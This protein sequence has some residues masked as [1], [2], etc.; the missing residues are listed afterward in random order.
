MTPPPYH[1]IL[2]IL[3]KL[4][5][6]Q[7]SPGMAIWKIFNRAGDSSDSAFEYVKARADIHMRHR[8]GSTRTASVAVPGRDRL[9]A[10]SGPE[11]RALQA[12]LC[13]SPGEPALQPG[14]EAETPVERPPAGPPPSDPPPQ[15][16]TGFPLRRRRGSALCP[17][18]FCPPSCCLGD[19]ILLAVA[20]ASV[21]LATSSPFSLHP[22]AC[23][24]PGPF[25]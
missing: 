14:A 3:I 4:P 7:N 19:V 18:A 1:V 13:G 10:S 2:Q 24:F 21:L 23:F 8:K 22:P 11:A 6:K 9:V 15:A 25:L 16:S 5:N 20:L 17:C 12:I